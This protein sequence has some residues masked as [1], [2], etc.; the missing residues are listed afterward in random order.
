VAT[1][2]FRVASTGDPVAP[3][4]L[5]V[6]PPVRPVAPEEPRLTGF[7]APGRGAATAQEAGAVGNE[8]VGGSA[9]DSLVAR[10]R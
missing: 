9:R 8:P 10:I 3:A 6:A 7:C 1:L 2:H 4:A 5:P